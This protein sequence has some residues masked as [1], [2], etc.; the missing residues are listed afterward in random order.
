MI[1]SKLECTGCGEI[2][3]SSRQKCAVCGK[4]FQPPA[5]PAK[6]YP[7]RNRWPTETPVDIV[8]NKLSNPTGR[9]KL[10]LTLTEARRLYD[11][12]SVDKKPHSKKLSE[13]KISQIRRERNKYSLK[14]LANK[15]GCSIPAVIKYSRGIE[16]Y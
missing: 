4:E 11:V 10:E 8:K 12:V 2:Y 1:N 14:E 3:F 16:V 6:Q 13:E 5:P 15:V 7:E 9:L